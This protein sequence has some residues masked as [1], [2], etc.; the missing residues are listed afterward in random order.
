MADSLPDD[1]LAEIFHLIPHPELQWHPYGLIDVAA[2]SKTWRGAALQSASLWSHIHTKTQR[3]RH[4]LPILLE[5]SRTSPLDVHLDLFCNEYGHVSSETTSQ[6]RAGVV[7]ALLP[8]VSRVRKLYLRHQTF[9]PGVDDEDKETIMRLVG[10]GV[11]FLILG[12][13]THERVGDDSGEEYGMFVDFKAS[14]LLQASFD[15]ARPRSGLWATILPTTL[16]ELHIGSTRIDMTLLGTIFQQCG[17][18]ASLSLQTN[19]NEDDTDLSQLQHFT[20]PPSIHTLDLQ[21]RMPD[22]VIVL[23]LFPDEAPPLNSITICD[24]QGLTSRQLRHKKPPPILVHMLRGLES[25]I[26]FEMYSDQ[27][28]ILRD[29][30]GR[31]RHFQVYA[32]DDESYDTAA[33]WA[34][35]VAHH[36][37]HLTVCTI[38]VTG[39]AWTGLAQALDRHQPALSVELQIILDTAQNDDDDPPPPL[40]LASLSRLKLHAPTGIQNAVCTAANV[41]QLLAMVHTD[42]R[43]VPACL[44]D[45]V[46]KVSPRKY[47]LEY[48]TLATAIPNVEPAGTWVACPHCMV[49]AEEI[50]AC[51]KWCVYCRMADEK[52]KERC[53]DN[54]HRGWAW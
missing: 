20:P 36:N 13:Y 41:L 35:L 53:D 30:A 21:M 22:L 8:H 34:F 49:R 24:D 16:R 11:E 14:N 1:I 38:R 27:D 52:T 31:T 3:D 7:Q 54:W 5:R 23:S 39:S 17:S 9:E 26:A 43:S 18:L 40:K 10:A 44:G 50:H 25:L 6:E 28:V 37:A 42:R 48:Q 51:G 29:A 46:L 4:F 2:V 15:G 45:V 33:L 19:F 32:E 12:E 47:L